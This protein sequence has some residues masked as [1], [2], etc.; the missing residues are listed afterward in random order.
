MD[1]SLHLAL[2]RGLAHECDVQAPWAESLEVVRAVPVE[3]ALIPRLGL[4]S[5]HIKDQ[6]WLFEDLERWKAVTVSPHH[7]VVE[8]DPHTLS[9]RVGELLEQLNPF[10]DELCASS[11]S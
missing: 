11:S 6:P 7:R 9:H 3:A 8:L 5:R 4:V 1:E 2:S 10:I